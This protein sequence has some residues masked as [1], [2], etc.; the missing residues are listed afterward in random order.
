MKK[1]LLLLLLFFPVLLQAQSAGTPRIEVQVRKILDYER[2]PRLLEEDNKK[3]T[4]FKFS[5]GLEIVTDIDAFKV[6]L[7]DVESGRTPYENNAIEKGHIRIKLEKPGYDDY[8]FWVNVKENYRTTVLIFYK[9]LNA[10]IRDSGVPSPARQSGRLYSR[11]NPG[12]PAYYRQLYFLDEEDSLDFESAVLY[13]EDGST[14]ISLTPRDQEGG[15]V[16]V[17]DGRD[18]EGRPAGTGEFGIRIA[19]LD[20][21]KVTVDSRYSRQAMSYFSGYSGLTLVPSAR[22]LFRKG[23]QFGSTFAMESINGSNTRDY[24][25]PFSF[26]LRLSPLDRW[27][28]SLEAETAFVSESGKPSLRIN[29]SQKV[30]LF[31]I[32]SLQVS[33]GVRG[34]Y[35]S[36]I[37]DFSDEIHSSLIRDPSG[38]SLFIPVQYRLQGWDFF[39]A[40]EIFYTLRPLSF[41]VD[42]ED[43]DLTGALRWGIQYSP[44]TFFSAGL[45]SALYFPSMRGNPLSMQA[46]VEGT[47]YIPEMPFYINLFGLVQKVQGEGDGTA[48]GINLGFLL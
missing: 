48:F 5:S 15:S 36:A 23:F 47:L 4:E 16:L 10:D 14:L 33:L 7:F 26:F 20:D 2:P 17:W 40:P 29:S 9:D 6:S 24:N 34:S 27:E 21:Y 28:A 30:Y 42:T 3:G 35:Q 12:D 1:R 22:L 45:S 46:A 31:D 18:A 19:A 44:G 37:N 43:P 39:G 11:F 41:N 25:L 38:G 13:R 8:S 32:Q